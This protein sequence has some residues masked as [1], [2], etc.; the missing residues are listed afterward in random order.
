MPLLYLAKVNLNSR[1]FDIYDNKLNIND[2]C[3]YVYNNICAGSDY[4]TTREDKYNDSYG[5]T[6]PYTKKSKYTF[7]EIDKKENG[8]VTG[9]LVRSFNKPTEK[10]DKNSGKMIITYNEE[11]V[12]I[13]FYYD[14]YR[15]MITFCERQSFGYNQFMEAFTQLLNECVGIYEFQIFLQKDKNVLEDKIK[16]LKIVHKVN[17]TLIPPNSNEDDM[18]E[19]RELVYM[20][21]CIDTNST[22]IKLEY[23]SDNMKMESNVMKDIMTAVSRGYGDMTASGI[24][25]EGLKCI[26]RSSHDAAYTSNISENITKENIDIESDKLITRFLSKLSNKIFTKR[27]ESYEKNC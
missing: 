4:I 7:Q 20:Q 1:I 17:A 6:L 2:V 10:L 8:I 18:N 14:I 9:K 26:V 23:A 13:Y 5:N 22:K 24:N 19:L 21:Q 27:K 12:S 16:T 3:D 11:N 25:N 15:E